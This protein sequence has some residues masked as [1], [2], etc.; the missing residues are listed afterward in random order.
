MQT[1]FKQNKKNHL[2]KSHD[3][4]PL[5]K[6]RADGRS[7]AFP[8]ISLKALC[9]ENWYTTTECHTFNNL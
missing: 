2:G 3:S 7:N 5:T 8:L 1:V 4:F 6:E 9:I